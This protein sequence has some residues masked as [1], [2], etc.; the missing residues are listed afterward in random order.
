MLFLLN[1]VVLNVEG[2]SLPPA[3]SP[4]R[5]KALSFYDLVGL[6][7]ELYAEAPLLHHALP[8]R[9]SRLAALIMAKAPA[10]N[11]ALFVAPA[12][13]CAPAAVSAQFANIDVT[14]LAELRRRQRADGPDP[15]AIDRQ[16]WRRLAA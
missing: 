13:A 12:F 16:I 5:L 14:V 7:Q 9:A 8:G 11:G 10:I 4:R 15:I 3:L 2:L 1:E 6:G